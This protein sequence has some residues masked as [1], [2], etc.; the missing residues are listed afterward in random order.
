LK[1]G[2]GASFISSYLKLRRADWNE[3]ARHLTEWERQSTLDC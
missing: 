2:L 3:Y 1:A